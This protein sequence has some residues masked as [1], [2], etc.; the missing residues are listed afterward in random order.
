V[1]GTEG[2]ATAKRLLLPGF[3]FEARGHEPFVNEEKRQV[4]VDMHYPERITDQL[5]YHLPA[6]MTVEGAPADA[7]FSWAGHAL[8]VAKTKTTPGSIVV[9]R[10]VAHAF[11]MTKPEE[12][13][14]LRGFY[15]KVAASDQEQLVLHTA[16]EEKAQIID[17]K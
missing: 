5:T 3:F 12:Y 17:V 8:Y 13:Q 2:A 16:A 1:S 11:T 4:A 15:Q 14:D 7:N 9:A 10:Q 6:G